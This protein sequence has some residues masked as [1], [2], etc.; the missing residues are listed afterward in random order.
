MPSLLEIGASFD[1]ISPMAHLFGGLVHGA[2]HT[3]N[4]SSGCGWSGRDIEKLLRKNGIKTWGAMV[5]SDTILI[6]VR[7]DQAAQAQAVLEQNGITLE[8]G[9]V[10]ASKPSKRQSSQPAQQAREP[11]EQ[12]G[13]G[14]WMSSLWPW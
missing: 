13:D 3:F 7:K 8:G 14:S 5:I 4:I 12:Q 11:E 2:G 9:M 6:T 10:E 1:I